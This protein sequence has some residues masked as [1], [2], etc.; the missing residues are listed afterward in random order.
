MNELLSIH[1]FCGSPIKDFD[2]MELNRWQKLTRK[3]WI[4]TEK[5][6]NASS[7]LILNVAVDGMKILR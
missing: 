6:A 4:S 7:I 3:S 2:G 5:I 1:D